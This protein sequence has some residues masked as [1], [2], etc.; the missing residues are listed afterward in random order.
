MA[1][2]S[3]Q[4]RKKTQMKTN[5]LKSEWLQILILALP[6]IV[7]ALLWNQ[8]PD[9][10]P[11]HWNARGQIDGYASK[12]FGTL[13]MPCINIVVALLIGLLPR[14]DPKLSKRDPESRAS[15]MHTIKILRIAITGFESLIAL[16]IILFA[17]KLF[18]GRF[19]FTS[20]ICI[21]S[22]LLFAVLGNFMSKLRPNYF[23]GIR[24][25]W[26]LESKDVWVKTHRLGGPLMVALGVVVML[27]GLLLPPNIVLFVFLPAV[28]GY[29]AFVCFY[30][31]SI[32]KKQGTIPTQPVS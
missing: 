15:L 2:V 16:A 5:L 19:D 31:Y 14:I 10:V 24:T 21:A 17:A 9:R 18:P 25:P 12:G 22:G 13:L 23:V 3:D 28:L 32:H 4:K 29:S 27:A 20:V 26:T 30:S 7:L 8:I 1:H 11:S 6:F